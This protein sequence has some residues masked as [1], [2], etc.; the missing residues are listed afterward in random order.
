MKLINIVLIVSILMFV[1][2]VGL[3]ADTGGFTV[4][5]GQN[6]TMQGWK[7][8]NSPNGTAST[9]LMTVRQGWDKLNKTDPILGR[10]TPQEFGATVNDG[11]DDT[12][13]IQNALNA[14]RYVY[15]PAGEYTQDPS[16]KFWG[17]TVGGLVLQDDSIVEFSPDA[18]IKNKAHHETHYYMLQSINRHNITIIN[19]NLDGNRSGNTET[20]GEWGYGI[21]I[22][23]SEN[24]NVQGGSF[25]NMWGDG[26]SV[27]GWSP[28]TTHNQN[29]VVENVL[30]DFNR[31][32][33][34]SIEDAIG[35]YVSG[36]FINANGT[37]PDFG[38]YIEPY[39]NLVHA[40]GIVLD[41]VQTSNNSRGII[42]CPYYMGTNPI[43]VKILNSYDADSYKSIS[44]AIA[45]GLFFGP[46]SATSN[47]RIV[48]ENPTIVD[49][50]EAGIVISGWS[51]SGP[52][53]DII[54]PSIIRPNRL[55]VSTY[56]GSAVLWNQLWGIMPGANVNIY[57]PYIASNDSILPSYLF[58]YAESYGAS[59]VIDT[60]VKLCDTKN[61]PNKNYMMRGTI[62]DPLHLDSAILPAHTTVLTEANCH[63]YYNN[64]GLGDGAWIGL[65]GFS[66]GQTMTFTTV[67]NAEL[68][69]YPE[70]DTCILPLSSNIS[71]GLRSS[72]VS[73]ES[74]TL[75]KTNDISW[76]ITEIIGTW[77]S[78]A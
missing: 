14:S 12:Q 4:R 24:V 15:F 7:V 49:S 43:D 70:G 62:I 74:V 45:S 33:G 46:A 30:C 38:I 23:A 63:R 17:E 52:N 48:V 61:T 9:D 78:E 54:N 67:N 41:N 3:A 25:R 34:L 29:I 56:Q 16:L 22:A 13:Y 51:Y 58:Y 76:Q 77:T 1:A 20:T 68:K 44:T 31:R 19:A 11:I 59:P 2:G 47:G 55:N 40:E 26:I 42:V 5:S 8:L 21:I 65:N 50:D 66:A 71:Y 69:L 32:G 72:G 73:G 28:Y 36:K 75:R 60:P 10:V 53:I 64:S 39:N 6:I 57:R 35:L 27:T 37:S 18:I